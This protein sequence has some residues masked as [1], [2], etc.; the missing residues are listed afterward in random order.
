MD[1]GSTGADPHDDKHAPGVLVV[2]D[3][4]EN[5]LALRAILGSPRYRVVEAASGDEALRRLLEDEFAVLL[6][7]VVMPRMDGF[8]LAAAI[9]ARPRTASVPILFMTAEATDLEL[10]L[11]GYRIGAADFLVK[12]LV[13]AMVRAKTEVFLE[14]HLQRARL[15]RQGR[16]LLE[17]ERREN[18]LRLMELRLAG[19][20]RYRNLAEA[21]PH[22][23]WTAQPDGVVDYF[24]RRWFEHTGLGAE[25]AA[26]SWRR[27]VHSDDLPALER[28][29]RAALEAGQTFEGECRLRA[30]AGQSRWFLMRAVPERGSSGQI[31]SW[32][33]TFTDIDDHKRAQAALVEFKH[34]LDVV[35]DA[36]MIFE[37]AS[38]RLVYANQGATALFGYDADDLARL[39]PHALFKDRDAALFRERVAPLQDEPRL[40]VEAQCRRGDGREVPVEFSFQLIGGD[41]GHVV[42][43]ARDISE[44]RL[45]QLEREQLYREAL[46]G[47]EARDEFLSVA[48]HELRTPLSTLTLQLEML[49]R[50]PRR[51]APLVLAGKSAERLRAIDRQV[52]RLTRLITQLMDVSR[53][54]AGRMLLELEDVDLGALVADVVSRFKDDAIRAG[55]SLAFETPPEVHGRWDRLRLE[56]VIT[57][58]LANALKYGAGHPVEVAV[59]PSPQ[60]ASLIVRD[61]GIGIASEDAERIFERFERAAPRRGYAGLGLGLFIVRRIVVA[62]GGTIRVASEP[63]AGSTFTVNLP[64][65]PPPPTEEDRHADDDPA[66]ASGGGAE[67]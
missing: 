11:K 24:N 42:S 38:W 50:P 18:E 14:L 45:A 51:E 33:G 13:P 66:H 22:V 7:D 41:R 32:L 29:W 8:E 10:L 20:R 49:M 15:E 57:N 30:A 40:T 17:A 35:L 53:I 1:V 43:I 48:S 67:A 36:V 9:R 60:E 4:Q 25:E 44:R 26:G 39:P 47:I 2:D 34:T 63:G 61:H 58:L 62:H 52:E 19:Q 65:E 64:Y 12:P 27:A 46:A 16:L 31:V 37:A 54:R 6:V 3:R 21:V 5:R 55:C 23:I 28:G 56:Q 59:A